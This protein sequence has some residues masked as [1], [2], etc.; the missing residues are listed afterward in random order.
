MAVPSGLDNRCGECLLYGAIQGLA[1]GL[2]LVDRDGRVFHLNRR[3]AELLNL[4]AARVLGSRLTTILRHPGL[5][6]F[7][8]RAALESDPVTTDL[9][10]PPVTAIRATASVCVSAAGGPI[11]RALLLRDVTREKKIHV[12]L[13]DTVARRLV[14]M[15]G[16]DEPAL[17][18][19]SLTAR[20]RQVLALLAAGLSNAAIAA[21]LHVSPNTV[22]SHLK[23][24]YPKLKVRNR[25][26]AV[27]YAL[28]HGIRPPTG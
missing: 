19:A 5:V 2:I 8:D 4:A 18:L 25:S 23:H 26:Q 13:S 21:R 20:E 14:E 12:E 3:A 24:I 9:T 15:A 16:G 11:G 27:V 22:G 1:D 7:W 17:P 28:S 6:D 10:F